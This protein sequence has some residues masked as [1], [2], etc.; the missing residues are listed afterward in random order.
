MKLRFITD[1]GHGWLE[2]PMTMI[3][4][5][6]I[7]SEIS[8]YSYRYGDMAYLE[9]DCDAGVFMS[10]AGAAGITV[11]IQHQE[12]DPTPIRRYQRFTV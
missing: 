9:E 10:A 8:H 11:E 7:A 5:L 3:Q 1:P 2:V 12:Q 4:T 6:G